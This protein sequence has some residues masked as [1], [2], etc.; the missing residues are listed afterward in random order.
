MLIGGFAIGK[1]IQVTRKTF[2]Y[3]AGMSY[4]LESK[5]DMSVH[6]FRMSAGIIA[7]AGRTVWTTGK[8]TEEF[9]DW[10]E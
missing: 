1:M 4:E 9:P 7:S 8:F 6:S 2:Q 10:Y 3:Y 5:M